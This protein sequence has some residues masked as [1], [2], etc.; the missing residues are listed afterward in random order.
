MNLQPKHDL[1]RPS[2]LPSPPQTALKILHVCSQVDV[3][4]SDLVKLVS[5]DPILSAEI[6][7]VVNSPYFGISKQV[8]S[9]KQAI[10]ILGHKS[11]HN[12]ALCISTRDVIKQDDIPGFAIDL[13][14]EDS[15][16]RASC[17]RLLAKSMINVDADECFT[18]GLL[19]DFGLLVMFYLNKD[20][21]NLW[22]DFRK[23][24]PDD[25]YRLELDNFFITH[26]AMMQNLSTAWGLP[27]WLADSLGQHHKVQKEV[28]MRSNNTLSAILYCSDWLSAVYSMS[29]IG[30]AISSCRKLTSELLGLDVEHLETLLVAI[31]EETEKAAS[32]IGLR[33]NEQA[34]YDQLMRNVNVKLAEENLDYQELN[35]KLEQT[36]TERDE[37]A[38]EFGLELAL[39]IEKQRDYLPI[40]NPSIPLTGEYVAAHGLPSGFYDYLPLDDGRYF[41]NLGEI[42]GEGINAAMSMARVS[43]L[44]RCLGKMVQ[45]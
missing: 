21:C 14:W 1:I 5:N 42:T 8:G 33:I 24:S 16:R 30:L 4:T 13:F 10:I 2:D 28:E 9:I 41:F 19:Q 43:S 3:K 32:A 22:L 45:D 26:D 7:R 29:D 35:W 39:A 15:L 31:P 18:A 36:L 34:N 11:L 17:A 12:L 38:T 25:R 44:C 37:N 40:D 27:D 6:L 23:E 20:K